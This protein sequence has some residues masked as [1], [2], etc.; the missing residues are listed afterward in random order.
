[1]IY[2][3]ITIAIV[4]LIYAVFQKIK[5]EEWQAKYWAEN[6]CHQ[7]TE[8]ELKEVNQKLTEAYEDIETF[9]K[10]YELECLEKGVEAKYIIYKQ[11]LDFLSLSY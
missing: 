10:N 5:H 8:L 4:F 7:A 3:V 11:T 2:L 1:M 6:R 9:S